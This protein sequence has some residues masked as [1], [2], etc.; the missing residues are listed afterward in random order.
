MNVT[1]VLCSHTKAQLC[2]NE[3]RNPL[4]PEI[5]GSQSYLVLQSKCHGVGGWKVVRRSADVT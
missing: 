4:Y 2:Q 5:I 3:F 1:N